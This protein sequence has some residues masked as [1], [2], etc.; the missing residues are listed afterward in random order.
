[1]KNDLWVAI[2]TRRHLPR[3]LVTDGGKGTLLKAQM[4]HAP[5][6]KRALSTF[7]EAL[8]LWE[9]RAVRAALIV[10]EPAG[11]ATSQYHDFFAE[12]ERTP[13]YSIEYVSSWHEVRSGKK[14]D[15][16]SGMGQFND[17]KQLLMFEVAR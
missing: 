15:P 10:G 12:P 7:L 14:R 1:M 4:N 16:I 9:G 2:D 17:L 3:I 13:Q 5:Q 11:F 8:A 6:H